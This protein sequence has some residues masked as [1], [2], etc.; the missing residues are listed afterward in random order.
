MN[1]DGTAF[2]HG[3]IDHEFVLKSS[4]IAVD[5]L[6]VELHFSILSTEACR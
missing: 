5:R 1:E 3:V 6:W 2:Y 4:L